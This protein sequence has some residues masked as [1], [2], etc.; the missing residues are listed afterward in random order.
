MYI[1]TG[2][3]GFIGSYLV[4]KLNDEGHTDIICVDRMGEDDRWKNLQG[5]K[6]YRY[7]HADDFIQPEILTDIFDEGVDAVY[8]MGACSSTT[9]KNIDF[10]MSNN[11]E[12][13]QILF[14]FCTQYD[15]PICYASSAATY[16]A[17]E[18][19][20]DDSEEEISQLMALNAYGY[21]K[22]LM[23]EWVLEQARKPSRWF[24]VKFFNVYGPNEYHKG[25]M[26]SVVCQAYNQILE[27]GKMK[28]FKSH[29][30]D[31]KDGEQLRDFVYVSDVVDAMCELMH[32]DH[33]GKSGIYNLGCGEPRTFKHLVESTFKAMGKK[34][35]IEFIDMPES[36]RNQYQYYTK[37]NMNKFHS[38]FPDFR[39]HS[40]EAG[41]ADY[42]QN[43]LMKPNPRL[44]TRKKNAS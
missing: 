6:Y 28:L 5:L 35:D 32:R 42:V 14:S 12:Y 36:L 33:D 22:Q 15:V 21:S 34:S 10:L 7:I 39:F 44:N 29:N 37:A 27:T 4:K 31:Y 38:V 26:K 8:H 17:G 16:G 30:P 25:N 1:I 2:A 23:D 13:S 40:V 20:Y 11:V 24:G 41:V 43:Y 18:N 3:A 9:E 19:G